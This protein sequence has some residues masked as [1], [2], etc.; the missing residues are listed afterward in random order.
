MRHLWLLIVFALCSTCLIATPFDDYIGN[1]ALDLTRQLQQKTPLVLV[2]DKVELLDNE[3][4]AEKLSEYFRETLHTH[5]SNSKA[6]RPLPLEATD[7]IIVKLGKAKRDYAFF[8][9]LGL[10][11]FKEMNDTPGG[12]LSCRI[13]NFDTKLKFELLVQDMQSM[14]EIATLVLEYPAD[15][16]TD[17]LLGIVREVSK[18]SAPKEETIYQEEAEQPEPTAPVSS[19]TNVFF[20]DFSSY[21]EGDSVSGWG[22]GLYVYRD[23]VGKKYLSSQIKGSHKAS[24]SFPFPASF[25]LQFDFLKSEGEFTMTLIDTNQQEVNVRVVK[26]WSDYIVRIS[27][28]V[29]KKTPVQDLNTLRITRSGSTL[30]L[31]LNGKFMVSGDYS[32]FRGVS[33]FTLDMQEGQKFT[34]FK[35]DKI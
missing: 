19:S 33:S 31:Y 20:E 22:K 3:H 5:L 2:L 24:Q 13:K 25:A 32:D 30:K 27:G 14:K 9:E 16:Q 15:P 18:V 6:L 23:K 7:K 1:S 28:T 4:P 10:L 17:A 21:K 12:F 34:D 11:I 35:V 29:E 26:S 8:S